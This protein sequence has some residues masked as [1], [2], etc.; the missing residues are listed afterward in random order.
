MVTLQPDEV[1]F[2]DSAFTGV[3]ITWE[4]KILSKGNS[5]AGFAESDVI[6]FHGKM[7]HLS[8]N[9]SCSSDLPASTFWIQESF[10][11][12]KLTK[13]VPRLE[14]LITRSASLPVN[15][16]SSDPPT[17]SPCSFNSNISL[18]SCYGHYSWV[19]NDSHHLV[20]SFTYF[21]YFCMGSFLFYFYILIFHVKKFKR[22]FIL[23]SNCAFVFFCNNFRI[24]Q[25]ERISWVVGYVSNKPWRSMN[26]IPSAFGN[27]IW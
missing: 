1:E 11:P 21:L 9:S 17:H 23:G 4:H 3:L 20:T 5:T 18:M 15:T 26:I 16:V 25:K 12:W 8:C 6:W 13:M 27:W 24:I 7:A 2:Q 10:L 22:N 19:P 14:S